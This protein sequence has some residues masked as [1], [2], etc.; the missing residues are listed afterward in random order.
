MDPP[1]CLS[2]VDIA[3]PKPN[4][5]WKGFSK[6]LMKTLVQKSTPKRLIQIHY[7]N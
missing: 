5:K 2:K 4:Q 6:T 1:P 3:Q 7:A